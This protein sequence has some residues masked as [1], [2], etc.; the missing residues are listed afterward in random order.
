MNVGKVGSEER[1]KVKSRDQTEV[2][3]DQVSSRLGLYV[4]HN[5]LSDPLP[6]IPK[7]VNGKTVEWTVQKVVV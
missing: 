7:K 3:L 2:A 4:N 6:L 1:L 5:D